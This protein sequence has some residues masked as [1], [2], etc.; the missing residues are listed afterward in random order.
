MKRILL[1]TGIGFVLTA[2][3]AR[4]DDQG[5]T[6][7]DLQQKVNQKLK[8]NLHSD[9]FPGNNL[10]TLPGASRHLPG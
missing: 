1:A 7:I 2:M 10:A 6:F 9:D 3:V 8:E 5:V 4:A